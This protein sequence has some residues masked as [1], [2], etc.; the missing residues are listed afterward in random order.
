MRK[1]TLALILLALTPTL[2]AA[3]TPPTAP[4]TIQNLPPVHPK[5][6]T[7]NLPPEMIDAL[8]KLTDDDYKIRQD[9]VNKLQQVLSRQFQQMVA[10]QNLMLK[11]QD[12][13]AS[14]LQEMTQ[15]AGSEPHSNTRVAGLME[16]NAALSRWAI[17]VMA[18]PEKDRNDLLAWGTKDENI[19]LIAR[20]YN[21]N[22][23]LR[24]KAAKELVNLN[25]PQA[26][27]LLVQL[28][29]DPSREVSLA[30]IDA[31]Y[32]KKP[33]PRV[34]AT[35]WDRA[36]AA[37]M[38]Q[39]HQRQPRQKQLNI[40]GRLVVIYDQ[41][42]NYQSR[43]QD[44]E[45]AVDALIHFNDPEITQRLDAMFKELASTMSNPN[46]YR[47]RIMSPNYG[48]AGRALARLVEHYK[49]R[50]AVAFLFKVLAI[51]NNDGS[52]ST[53]N[54]EK[55]R[56][57]SRIDAAAMIAK[58]IGQDPDDYKIKRYANWGDR[59]MIKGGVPEEEAV[60]KKLQGWWKENRS[61]YESPSAPPSRP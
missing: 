10:L 52:D 54:H 28:L 11:V 12:G 51:E 61:K 56:S 5:N 1:T 46:D 24:A 40:H 60:V 31:V 4:T 49:P 55:F 37:A 14:Q 3:D 26:Q 7:V 16:F 42:P 29:N 6:G 38:N 35:L 30:A 45:V 33:A 21:R 8:K 22:D 41:D 27:W 9:A 18:L 36:T 59:W 58:L 25:T 20:A 57:S 44:A 17:D 43:M 50:E 15:G 53:M 48:E 13:L 2:R 32:D 47:W 23:D 19:P 34:V 39:I